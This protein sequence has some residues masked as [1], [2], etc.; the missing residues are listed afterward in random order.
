MAHLRAREGGERVT[1]VVELFF[2]LVYVFAV[3]QLSHLL[4]GGLSWAGAGRTAFLLLVVWWAWIY[5]TWMVNWFDPGSAPVRVVLIFVALASLLMAS[6]LPGAFGHD[7][8]LFAGAYVVLQVGRNVAGT[9]LLARDHALRVVFERIVV[10]SGAAGALWIAGAF[11]AGDARLWLWAPALV[12]EL[13]A[14]LVGYRTPGRGVSRTG[15]YTIDGGQFA[16]RCQAFVIIALG[17]SIVITGATAAHAG[18]TF[19]VVVSLGV[20]FFVSSGL[21]WLYFGEVAEHSRRDMASSEDPGRLA[22]D[23]YTYL[24]LPIIAGVIVTAVGDEL[25]LARPGHPLTSAGA[26]AVL[27]GPALF[28]LGDRSSACA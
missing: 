8:A 22:R 10:W 9:L 5:T 12:V 11:L 2:D 14:P 27:G 13:V 1:T 18:L 16:E 7:A 17:E 15:D 28:L 6:A 4:I 20:A 21:W 3:T 25:L 26:M 19:E 24:H 23:A